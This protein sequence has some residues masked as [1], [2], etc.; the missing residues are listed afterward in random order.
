LA[1]GFAEDRLEEEGSDW[2]LF[3]ALVLPSVNAPRN[4][5]VGVGGGGGGGGGV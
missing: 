1:E 4:L 5:P 2:A 3:P